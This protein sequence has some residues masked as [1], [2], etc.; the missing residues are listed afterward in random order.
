MEH[1]SSNSLQEV[2]CNQ[3]E[4]NS[5]MAA[6]MDTIQ[7]GF[8]NVLKKRINNSSSLLLSNA[9]YNTTETQL[10]EN[11]SMGDNGYIS[12]SMTSPSNEKSREKNKHE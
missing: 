10:H 3:D 2:P 12:N 9:H 8:G 5:R 7:N 4:E 1:T 11:R 6:D